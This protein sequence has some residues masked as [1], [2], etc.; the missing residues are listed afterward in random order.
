MTTSATLD[1]S[2][3]QLQAGEQVVIPLQIRNNGEIVEGYQIEVVGPDLES[4]SRQ[5]AATPSRG[6]GGG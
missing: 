5:P 2:S 3:V 6:P 4:R 1:S